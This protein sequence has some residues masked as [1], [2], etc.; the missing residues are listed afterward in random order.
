LKMV[1]F[2]ALFNQILLISFIINIG[3]NKK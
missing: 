1:K 3:K 2:V